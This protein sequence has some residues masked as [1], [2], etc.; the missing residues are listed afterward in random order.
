MACLYGLEPQFL[1]AGALADR[2]GLPV[3]SATIGAFEDGERNV[4][5]HDR[6]AG[7]TA[8]LVGSTGPPVDASL[9]AL[10]LLADAARRAGARDIVA[11]VP[12]FGY[13]RG[14]RLAGPGAAVPC[15]VAADILAGAG[16]RHLV[17]VDL[18]SPAIA[19]FFTIQVEEVS[20]VPLLADRFRGDLAEG[21]VAVAPDA[22]AIKRVSVFAE[23]LGIPMAIA[24]KQRTG[25]DTPRLIQL[26]GDVAGMEAL[27]LDDM[28]TT[29]NT[30]LQVAQALSERGARGLSVAA[31]HAVMTPGAEARLRALGLRRFVTTDTLPYHPA[32]DW[33]AWEAI[34]LAPLLARA[35]ARCLPVGVFSGLA[36]E[37]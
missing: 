32:T 31:T 34:S 23:R 17:T 5:I 14:E 18:H 16:V 6:L 30:I 8:I 27:I 12:Y 35:I 2:L 28:V 25:P 13:A 37:E 36:P 3:G 33:P 24:T 22:G 20:A 15:R 21:T 4:R 10:A 19:G 29:G 7:R 11:V 9:V 1:L 26:W